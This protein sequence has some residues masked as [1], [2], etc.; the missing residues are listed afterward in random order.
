MKGKRFPEFVAGEL[1]SVCTSLVNQSW[2]ALL[3]EIKA[4]L[5]Q[6]QW[7]VLQG[8]CSLAKAYMKTILDVKCDWCKRLP[9]SLGGLAHPC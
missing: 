1:E 9:W 6:G 3:S 4:P 2:Q 8:D 7:S 5:D